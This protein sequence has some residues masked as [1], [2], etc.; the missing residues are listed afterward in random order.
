MMLRQAWF[1]ARKDV[2]LMLRQRETLLWVFVM[3]ILF[4]YFIGTVTGGFDG[5]AGD[6]KDSLAVRGADR[7]G[8][9]VDELIRR[10]EAQNFEIR[11][12][13]SDEAFRAESRRLIIPVPREGAASF[14]DA[15]LA[16][17]A[18]IL[19]FERRDESP[20]GNFDQ[21][22]IARAAYEVLGDLAAVKIAGND[23]APQAFADLRAMPRALTLTVKPAGRRLDPP[24]GFSQAIPGTM[25]MFTMLVLLT[26]GAITLVVEREQGLLRR[27][28]SAPISAGSLVAGKWMGRMALALVQIGFAMIVGRV[29][30]GMDWG[31]SLPMVGLVL[32]GW[33]AFAASSAV[34]LSSLT[35]TVGQTTGVGVMLT[36]VL[37]A[38]GGCWWPIEITPD[39]MQTLARLLPTGWAMDAMHKLIN[40]GDPASAAV[41]HLAAMAIGSVVVAWIGTRLF[42]YQ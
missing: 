32:V 7:G 25:V 27:L 12:P 18:Q 37:A 16:G 1:I 42:R 15:V 14:T 19:T 9:L 11:R 8:F 3:P 28:A 17:Q 13:A 24:T 5:P 4:F 39:W 38:L 31:R 36:M 41:P 40:F 35:R 33:A 6:R 29:L 21:I 10:L 23:P 2:A 34:L 20:T 26:S 30:F 22:R